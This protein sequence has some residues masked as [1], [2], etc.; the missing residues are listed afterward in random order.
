MS[1]PKCPFCG[2]VMKIGTPFFDKY[3]GKYSAHAKC[4]E[5]GAQGPIARSGSSDIAT[6]RAIKSAQFRPI[7]KPL[8]WASLD[9]MQVVW[10]EDADKQEVIPAFPEPVYD[11]GVMSFLT[12]NQE[13]ITAEKAD[14]GKR[15]R[16]WASQPTS[17]ERKGTPWTKT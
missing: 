4:W 3:S 2:E 11:K 12:Y 6:N 5:C 9:G 13:F 8:R 1:N 16:A 14:F 15:W 17:K 7:Q 10:L